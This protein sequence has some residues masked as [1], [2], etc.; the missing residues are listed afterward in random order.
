MLFNSLLLT[1]IINKSWEGLLEGS[2][3]EG[4]GEVLMGCPGSSAL[5][6]MIS[7]G[8]FIMKKQF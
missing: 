4:P 5:E 1:F 7:G 8:N 3:T 6:I 2:G